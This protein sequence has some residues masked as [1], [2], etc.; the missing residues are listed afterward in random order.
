MSRFIQRQPDLQTKWNRKFHSQR[1]RCEDPALTAA[2]FK[3][4]NDTLITYG[5]Q[6]TDIYNFN[7]TGFIMGVAATS[8]VV[9]SSDYTRTTPTYITEPYE[10]SYRAVY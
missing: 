3:L 1:A 9:T 8:K 4:I 6:D 10:Y 2:W 7:K 5:I